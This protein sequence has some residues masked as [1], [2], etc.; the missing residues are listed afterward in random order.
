MQRAAIVTS[1]VFLAS[2]A[3]APLRAQQQAQ[4]PAFRSSVDLVP[5]DVSVIAGD[6]KPVS[7]LKADD[8]SLT[9]DGRQRRVASAEFLSAAGRTAAAAP[10][11]RTVEIGYSTNADAGG[12]LIMLVVDQGSI[13]PGRGRAAMESAIR[14]VSQLSPADKVALITIPSS[15]TQ[16]DFTRN[17][18]LVAAALPRLSGQAETHPTNYRIGVS[19][20]VAIQRGDP[21]T[22]ASVIQR[23]CG[24]ARP[25]EADFCRSRVVA[26]I[27]GI[28]SLIH[29]RTQ[30]TLGTLRSLLDRLA[31]TPA[32][33]TLI[34]V[35]EGLV[36]ERVSDVAWIGVAAAKAQVTIQ[37]LHLEAPTADASVVREPVSPGRDRTLGREGLELV[38]SVTRGSV[39]Q[40]ASAADNA[41]ARLA[42]ELS[43][44]YLLSFE[45]ESSDRDGKPHKIKVSLPGRSGVEIRARSEFAVD[46]KRA[47]TDDEILADALRSP[48]LATDIGLRINAFSL[49]DLETARLRVL[50]IA[51][52]DRA[53]NPDGHLA[54]AYALTDAGGK[55]VASEIERDVKAP[56]QADKTQ[57][58]TTFLLASSAGPHTIKLAVLDSTGRRGSVEHE[59]SLGLRTMGELRTAD[60]LLAEDAESGSDATPSIGG[61]FTSGVVNTYIELYSDVVETLKAATV[62]FEIAE[63]E[64]GRAMDGAV[65]RL[66]TTSVEAP[67]RRA[68]EASFKTTLLPPGN[69]VV[70]AVVSASGQ[71]LGSVTRPFRVGRTAV[72]V[73]KPS[74]GLGLKSATRSA[75]IPFASRTERFDRAAVLTPQVVGFFMERM[76]LAAGGESSA[77][78]VIEHAQA[79]RFDQAMSSLRARTGTVPAAFLAGLE[80]YAKGELDAAASKFRDALR[81]DSEFFPAAFYLGSCYAAGGR[82]DQAV[83]AWQ[84]SLV[85]QSDAAFIF[86]LLGDA[87]L[88]LREASQAIEV[89]NEAA[90]Q[91]PNDEE[92]QVRLGAAYAMSGKR[93]EALA[94]LEPY[95]ASHPQDHER[96]LIALRT[97]YEARAAGTPVRSAEEDRALFV[98]LAQAY[99]AAK[100]PQQPLV[101]VW[102]RT[103]AK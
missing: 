40:V 92:V 88:R 46:Y 4:A 71:R 38:S 59:F 90:A 7:G 18:A 53:A 48:L 82:D 19:E 66:R 96:H 26:D 3:A 30:N 67:N 54:L 23:E 35:S 29:E 45:P 60:L 75:S 58:Y 78:A 95:L 80:L 101:D 6:G 5:V 37:A 51:Q 49:K 56:V 94:K 86:T 32:P 10:P 55:V 28:A 65:G 63:K 77:A 34:L 98:Q 69:Y 84:L 91:W 57:T 47:R 93:A 15:A 97:L 83:G 50:L 76:N 73:A 16:I 87:L 2:G 17:H 13:G 79:G 70:R 27:N 42:L 39:F 74:S 61:E 12:R 11:R 25:E 68:L 102:Q 81:M 41:F 33:K 103:M 85:T 20:A 9:V 14:F 99:A 62:M 72:A 100:G 52:I 22:L 21:S 89:L 24:S 64:D 43:G 8:F 36:L 44:Y 31:Q 1:L